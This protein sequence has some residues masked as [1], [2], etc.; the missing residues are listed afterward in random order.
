MKK[1]YV[2]FIFLMVNLLN[3]SGSR[4]DFCNE[5]SKIVQ[6]RA[7]MPMQLETAAYP[8]FAKVK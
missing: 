6:S 8:S 1:K 4:F 7:L 5:P 2:R 3:P